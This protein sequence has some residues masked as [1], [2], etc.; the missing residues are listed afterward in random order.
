M[1]HAKTKEKYLALDWSKP[2][3]QLAEETGISK[4][5]LYR[6]AQVYG[7]ERT[8]CKRGRPLGSGQGGKLDSLP[9]SEFTKR[10]TDIAKEQGVSREYVRQIRMKRGLPKSREWNG[11]AE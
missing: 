2:I 9:D 10:D 6:A 4:E 7:I 5:N 11:G 3:K 1:T 8:K